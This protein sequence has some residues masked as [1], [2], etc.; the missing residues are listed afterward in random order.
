MG[1]R[2]PLQPMS[3]G[4]FPVRGSGT[5]SEAVTAFRPE[6]IKPGHNNRN[7]LQATYFPSANQFR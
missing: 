3:S 1:R 6:A 4:F 7:S 2:H 5:M